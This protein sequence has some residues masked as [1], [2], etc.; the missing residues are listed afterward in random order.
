MQISYLSVFGHSIN[1]GKCV[2]CFR[3][4]KTQEFTQNGVMCKWAQFCRWKMESVYMNSVTWK[5]SLNN[6]SRKIKQTVFLITQCLFL[7]RLHSSQDGFRQR[8]VLNEKQIKERARG[9]YEELKRLSA[10]IE[11]NRSCW[12]ITT[13]IMKWVTKAAENVVE[14]SQSQMSVKYTF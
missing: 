4:K 7:K 6:H 5:L 13:F 12:C 1:I 2:E 10:E 8:W 11:R 14:T 9:R 3:I